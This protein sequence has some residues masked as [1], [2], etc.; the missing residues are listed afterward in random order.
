MLLGAVGRAA[1]EG[2]A[3]RGWSGTSEVPLLSPLRL[4]LTAHA[5]LVHR[6]S[7]TVLLVAARDL[8]GRGEVSSGETVWRSAGAG[9]GDQGRRTAGG[10]FHR[11]AVGASWKSK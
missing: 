9:D 7:P 6:G 4:L 8:A 10:S 1:G 11:G 3:R 5:W 2:G